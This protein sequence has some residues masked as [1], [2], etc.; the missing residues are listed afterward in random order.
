MNEWVRKLT[1]V[2]QSRVSSKNWKYYLNVSGQYHAVD[3]MMKVTS[4]DTLE[5][6]DFTV[7]N[8]KIHTATAK[9]YR[10]PS[11]YYYSLVNNYPDQISLINSI[12]NPL[13]SMQPSMRR[14]PASCLMPK[15][16]LRTTNTR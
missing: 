3:T 2:D 6:I 12:L 10:P 15:S 7:A 1:G 13:T 11:R 5:T 9:A 4:L 16:T 14:T 8:L